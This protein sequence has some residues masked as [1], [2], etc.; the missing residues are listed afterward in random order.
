M[1]DF[2]LGSHNS[3]SYLTPKKW[4]MKLLAFTAKCQAVDIK[5]QYEKYGVRC[6]DLRV[7]FNKNDGLIL[8]HGIVEYNINWYDLMFWLQYL[9]DRGDCFVRVIHEA[10]NKKE[11]TLYSKQ[12][13]IYLCE[14]IICDFKNITFWC[15]RNLYN[16]EV[17]FTFKAT[18]S[19]E[20][21]YSSVKSPKLIDDWWPWLYAKRHNKKIKQEGTD[22]DILL[23]DFVDIT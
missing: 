5:T 8:A 2:I 7:R 4:W 6:F 13:F 11:Y 14:D 3:W 22:K 18:P 9:N 16:W 10:R 21:N 20:E 12:H 15:G 23:I 1:K 17:D 19:C